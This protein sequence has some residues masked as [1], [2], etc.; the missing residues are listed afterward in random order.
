MKY[1]EPVVKIIMFGNEDVITS[2][3]SDN[4]GA[5]RSDWSGW[6]FEFDGGVEGE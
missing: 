2:S 3:A 1:Q 5:G 4:V 6:S